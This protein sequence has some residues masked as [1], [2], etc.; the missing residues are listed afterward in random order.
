[1]QIKK[2]YCKIKYLLKNQKIEKGVVYLR[3]LFYCISS[4]WYKGILSKS[5]NSEGIVILMIDQVEFR[6]N[7]NK[8]IKWEI[9][10]IL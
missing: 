4:R 6:L 8:S 1:M 9:K 3:Y 2:G 10:D 7:Q 5:K